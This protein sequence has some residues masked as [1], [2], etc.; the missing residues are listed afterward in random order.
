MFVKALILSDSIF[1]PKISIK[2]CHIEL[3]ITGLEFLKE[4]GFIKVLKNLNE[5]LNKRTVII[6]QSSLVLSCA[7]LL[8]NGPLIYDKHEPLNN[9]FIE[10]RSKKCL[11]CCEKGQKISDTKFDTEESQKNSNKIDT[12]KKNLKEEKK[13]DN[14]SKNY[15]EKNNKK[16]NIADIEYKTKPDCPCICFGDFRTYTFLTWKKS[17]AILPIFKD[18]EVTLLMTDQTPK[19]Q[20]TGYIKKIYE[21]VLFVKI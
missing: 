1:S 18:E 16:K 17:T 12:K 3:Q 2:N 7:Y 10:K 4:E 13:S 14:K 9:A 5:K 15:M 20:F 19:E 11:K 6:G 8:L 21:E